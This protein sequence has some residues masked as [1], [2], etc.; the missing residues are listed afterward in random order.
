M[1]CVPK[2]DLVI[3]LQ[4]MF[5]EQRLQIS[6]SLKEGPALLHELMQ[7][8][9]KISDSGHDSYG[10]WPRVRMMIWCWLWRCVLAREARAAGDLG[11]RRLF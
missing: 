6:R 5:Q 8:R 2:R 7:M 4:V 10:C 3:G 1:W 11:T 9:V